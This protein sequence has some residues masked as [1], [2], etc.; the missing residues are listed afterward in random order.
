MASASRISLTISCRES[1]LV[2]RILLLIIAILAVAWAAPEL[3]F[4]KLGGYSR[5]V[6]LTKG[7]WLE[8]WGY[9][10]LAGPN[11]DMATFGNV[12]GGFYMTVMDEAKQDILNAKQQTY[13]IA[14]KI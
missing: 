1:G 9:G 2:V 7:T 3:P 8:N 6:T 12:L 11:A 14:E 13:Q 5:L 4:L 10:D